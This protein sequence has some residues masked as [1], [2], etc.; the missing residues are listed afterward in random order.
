MSSIGHQ[1]HLHSPM[2]NVGD[3]IRASECL[4][5]LE[6]HSPTMLDTK[7]IDRTQMIREIKKAFLTS[8]M[9]HGWVVGGRGGMRDKR[10]QMLSALETG[11]ETY[12]VFFFFFQK[13]TDGLYLTDCL[14]NILVCSVL[15]IAESKYPF[16]QPSCQIGLTHSVH[17]KHIDLVLMSCRIQLIATAVF[18]LEI[19]LENVLFSSNQISIQANLA[20]TFV[21]SFQHSPALCSWTAQIYS[22]TQVQS[23]AFKCLMLSRQKGLMS[24][25]VLWE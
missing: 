25:V 2:E 20:S 14:G 18:F 23:Q 16:S 4:P 7:K 10:S 9:R 11:P 12:F 5:R 1:S 6:M 24:L 19:M 22:L 13:V 15:Q 17:R 3:K 8:H 21:L